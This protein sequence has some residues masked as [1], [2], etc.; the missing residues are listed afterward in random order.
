M[1]ALYPHLQLAVSD[2]ALAYVPGGDVAVASLAWVN[3]KGQAEFLPLEPRVYGTFDLSDDGR[4]LA[5]QVGD[6]TKDFILLYDMERGSSR[7][8]PRPRAPG[9]RN[10]R[11]TASSSPTRALRRV[12]RIG[13]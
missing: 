5:I 13:S 10:G 1:H 6:A 4:R 7:R 3:R 9:G 12:S 8:C 11:R 2:N